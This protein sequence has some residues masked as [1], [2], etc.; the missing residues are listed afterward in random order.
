MKKT[1]IITFVAVLV[2]S[3]GADAAGLRVQDMRVRDPYVVNVGGERPYIMYMSDTWLYGKAG[4]SISRSADLEN[5]TEPE[6]VLKA[7]DWL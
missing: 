3:G 6:N 5:W 4:V 2:L 1:R 7:P